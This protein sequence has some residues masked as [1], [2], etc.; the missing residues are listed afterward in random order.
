MSEFQEGDPLPLWEGLVVFTDTTK[1]GKLTMTV[2][3]DDEPDNKITQDLGSMGTI[4]IY[5]SYTTE[6]KHEERITLS[7]ATLYGPGPVLEDVKR[8]LDILS[9]FEE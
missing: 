9:E 3:R 4:R 6:L 1:D 8:W 5:D 2:W 7:R